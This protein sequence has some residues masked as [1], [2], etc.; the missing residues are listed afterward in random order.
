MKNIPTFEDFVNESVLNEAKGPDLREVN[1]VVKAFNEKTKF[2][3]MMKANGAF[4][5]TEPIIVTNKDLDLKGSASGNYLITLVYKFGPSYESQSKVEFI[6]VEPNPKF[7]RTM[8]VYSKVI[9]DNVWEKF[10]KDHEKQLLEP[11]SLTPQAIK[12]AGEIVRVFVTNELTAMLPPEA[13]KGEFVA[14][15]AASVKAA[16]EGAHKDAEVSEI[17]NGRLR[18]DFYSK[19]AGDGKAVPKTNLLFIVDPQHQTVEFKHPDSR[20]QFQDA[21]T[22]LRDLSR[23]MKDSIRNWKDADRDRYEASRQEAFRMDR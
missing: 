7:P 16:I 1:K 22:S 2:I 13:P 5:C 9:D 8:G 6:C 11:E 10:K 12:D 19:R 21:Y 3:K 20:G 4:V 14:D 18:V 17:S 15:N 23:F